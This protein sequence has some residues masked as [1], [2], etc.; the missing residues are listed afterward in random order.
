MASFR[1]IRCPRFVF[2]RVRRL[3]AVLFSLAV[4][5]FGRVTPTA[6]ADADKKPGVPAESKTTVTLNDDAVLP[7]HGSAAG[8]WAFL[9]SERGPQMLLLGHPETAS[10]SCWRAVLQLDG[11]DRMRL[12]FPV[13]RQRGSL[14]LRT[15]GLPID[16]STSGEAVVRVGEPDAAGDPLC[17][18]RVSLETVELSSPTI[19]GPASL[20]IDVVADAGPV[21]LRL[22]RIAWKTETETV[23]ICFDPAHRPWSL[24]PTACS[25][26]M[27]STLVAALIEWDWRMQD[28][29]G[30]PHEACTFV[31]AI[32]KRIPQIDQLADNLLAAGVNLADLP[33]RWGTLKAKI[34]AGC[35]DASCD[36]E[37]DWR[38]MHR[39]RRAMVL[40]NPLFDV[41]PLVFVKHVPS[42]M[43]H[44][45]TQVYG[46]A[47]RPGGGVFVLDEPGR[48]M[49]V[50]SLTQ[51]QFPPGNFMHTEVSFDGKRIYFAFCEADRSPGQW[52]DPETM[53]RH[54][55]IYEM[56]ARGTTIEKLTD[57]SFDHFNPTC[58]PNGSL[59]LVSTRRGG[60][61][62]CGSGPC[63]V[64]TLTALDPTGSLD[65][66]S[67][68][69]PLSFHETNEWDPSVL[70]DGRILYTRWDYVDRDAVYYQNLWTIRPDGTDAHRLLRQSHVLSNRNLGIP[71]HPRQRQSRCHCRSAPWHECRV[72]HLAR[73]NHGY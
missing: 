67:F 51:H 41:G 12:R 17:Q 58:L 11:G 13:P 61:H 19:D 26:N 14:Q 69:Y 20:S 56:S 50:R 43:S 18:A 72:G 33:E 46:Y 39:I 45:L 21:A 29:I 71:R 62:R 59:L 49:S 8:V 27:R 40:R 6:M 36:S 42:V 15:V 68:I 55:Q 1:A 47:A 57:G 53:D 5:C 37:S 35:P 32:R 34:A 70:N 10:G 63:Y 54:Y 64:Y 25:P 23:P 2:R 60:Y 22:E 9:H 38:E 52:R 28:G 73:H 30:T 65:G 16:A 66:G 44:Q 7:S 4:F 24:D 48:S 31:E 3:S